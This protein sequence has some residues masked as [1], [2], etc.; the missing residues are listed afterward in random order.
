M[1]VDKLIYPYYDR[2]NTL[3]LG[4]KRLL[5][6]LIFPVMIVLVLIGVAGIGNDRIY[7]LILIGPSLYMLFWVLVRTILW[8]LDG[9]MG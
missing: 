9:F 5:F 1:N 6:L 7:L 4:I 8:V 3:N 2:F